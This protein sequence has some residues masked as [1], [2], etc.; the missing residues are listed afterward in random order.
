MDKHQNWGGKRAGSG[1]KSKWKT[2]DTKTLRLPIA[3]HERVLEFARILDETGGDF[4]LVTVS[5]QK[6]DSVTVSRKLVD[7]IDRW[8]DGIEERTSPRWAKAKVMLR[9]LQAILKD[10]NRS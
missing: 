1:Q 8:S 10:C 7:F 6:D 4:D 9:E 5:S 3:M 2:G